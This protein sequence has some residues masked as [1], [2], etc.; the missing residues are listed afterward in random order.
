MLIRQE[1]CNLIFKVIFLI[2][3]SFIYYF[4]K[5]INSYR[6]SKYLIEEIMIIFKYLMISEFDLNIIDILNLILRLFTKSEILIEYKNTLLSLEKTNILPIL[7]IKLNNLNLLKN[8]NF[9]LENIK[10]PFDLIQSLIIK[11]I[12]YLLS[13][14]KIEL[15]DSP[16]P[17]KS[18]FKDEE[19]FKNNEIASNI[20]IFNS[21]ISK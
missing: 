18:V 1:I 11:I 15:L 20:F 3:L 9:N 2:F 21:R 13:N 6:K 14:E 17:K 10:N 12:G 5:I 4:K 7:I 19:N 8:K 16:N